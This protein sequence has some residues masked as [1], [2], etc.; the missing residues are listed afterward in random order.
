MAQKVSTLIF[1]FYFLLGTDRRDSRVP[2]SAHNRAWHES[3]FEDSGDGRGSIGSNSSLLPLD[4]EILGS[5]NSSR[6]EEEGESPT[7]RD[8]APIHSH[9]L[10]CD[11]D[12]ED[13]DDDDVD[14]EDESPNASLFSKPV[15]DG[16]KST[17]EAS[18]DT[19][20]ED[21]NGNHINK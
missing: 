2:N 7:Q 15:L 21:P 8:S 1:I 11:A 17:V 10:E 12:G 3:D 18:D 9:S 13:D 20:T 6:K 14:A 4:Q 5:A 19:I 16:E